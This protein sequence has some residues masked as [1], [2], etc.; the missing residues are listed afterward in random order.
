MAHNIS[1]W[2][3]FR[4]PVSCD[5]LVFFVDSSGTLFH[6]ACSGVVSLGLSS[7]SLVAPIF[8]CEE[9]HHEQRAVEQSSHDG[10]HS[11][12][13]QLRE[14]NVNGTQEMMVEIALLNKHR[15]M[16]GECS[17]I[18]GVNCRGVCLPDKR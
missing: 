8:R 18:A 1:Y 6:I 2:V 12:F 10:A 13:Q 9:A 5:I 16:H 4:S 17:P 15:C 14:S 3:V 7:G 11:S